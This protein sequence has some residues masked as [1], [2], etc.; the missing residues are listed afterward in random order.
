MLDYPTLARLFAEARGRND[1]ADVPCPECGPRCTN[2][3]NGNARKLRIWPGHNPGIFTFHCVRCDL[4]GWAAANGKSAYHPPAAPPPPPV[5]NIAFAAA[6]WRRTS[7]ASGT[8]V[9]AYLRSR[10]LTLPI[11]SRIRFHPQLKHP[12]DSHW[13]GMV[14]LVTDAADRPVAVHR[15][16]IAR[17]GLNKAPIEPQRMSLGPIRGGAVRLAPAAEEIVVGEGL[18]TCLSITQATGRPAWAALSAGGIRALELPPAIRSVII[19]VDNDDAG[20]SRDAAQVAAQRWL[21]EGR[22]VRIALPPR[23]QDF[24]DVLVEGARR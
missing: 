7:R 9:E 15:T 23:G 16:W 21:Q 3:R 4:D 22:R 11:S 20:E 17:G 8:P 1:F 13:P 6:I 12:S 19:A 24:N 10:G 18:E 5:D 14:A 2:P